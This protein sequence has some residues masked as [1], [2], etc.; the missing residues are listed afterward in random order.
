MEL[1]VGPT[2]RDSSEDGALQ[3][4]LF[5]TAITVLTK[6][7]PNRQYHVMTSVNPRDPNVNKA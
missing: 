1:S 3:G 2:Y 5:Q 6:K 4:V 7:E